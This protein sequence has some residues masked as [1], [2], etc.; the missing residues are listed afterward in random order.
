MKLLSYQMRAC[1]STGCSRPRPA[2]A[3]AGSPVWLP[4]CRSAPP[5]RRRCSPRPRRQSSPRL[6]RR[7]PRRR[8][9]P[10]RFLRRCRCSFWDS[11]K[12]RRRRRTRCCQCCSWS[13]GTASREGSACWPPGGR[14][15]GRRS[16]A[17]SPA[18]PGRAPSCSRSPAAKCCRWKSWWFCGPAERPAA[19]GW[20]A[21]A[22][23]E[24]GRHSHPRC[25]PC[26]S[27]PAAPPSLLIWR[28]WLLSSQS[29][30]TSRG[31][32]CIQNVTPGSTKT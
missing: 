8:R 2:T 11:P 29:T 23:W 4:R 17:P 18:G 28:T 16:C 15:P 13:P 25:C 3:A 26:C 12:R 19:A 27:D 21:R 10:L 5:A 14:A 31:P 9:L 20:A 32:V 24:T 7:R 22:G 6:S 1:P 30:S